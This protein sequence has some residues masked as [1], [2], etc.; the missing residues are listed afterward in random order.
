MPPSLSA[1]RPVGGPS[2]H[3]AVEA[4][5]GGPRDGSP[6][7]T[8]E[9]PGT[10]AATPPGARSSTLLGRVGSAE[11]NLLTDEASWSEELYEM[12]GR[13]PA[14]PA[15]T[16]D[17]LP[18]LVH[19]ADR[20]LLTAM[21][22]DCLVDGRPI[23]GEFRTVRPD[24]GIRT[25]HMMGEP[26]LDADGSTASMW[27]VLRD[28]GAVRRSR[29]TVGET[30]GPLEPQ[31][32]RARTGQRL[33]TEVRQTV[34]PPWRGPLRLPRQGPGSLDLAARSLPSSTGAAPG[35]TWYEAL[36]L[37][38]GDTLL[39]V[40]R[41]AGDPVGVASGLATLIGAL[42]GMALAGT[43]PGQLLGLLDQVL[44]ASLQPVLGSAVCCRYRPATR[45][46]SWAQAGHPAP[47]LYRGRTGRAL[48]APDGMPLGAAASAAYG[49]AEVTLREGD[50]LLLHTDGLVPAHRGTPADRLL[51]GLG[52]RLGGARTVQDC[53]RTVVEEF[54][55]GE[56]TDDACLL[57]AQ[58]VS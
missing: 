31:R 33:V 5:P 37:P 41:L 8:A 48:S 1:D 52:P 36:E 3:G 15:L 27:A 46:L 13:D 39:S 16:L 51:T 49:Q 50:V 7:M 6:S 53:V 4:H 18:S 12:L 24:G 47:L 40:G 11:W 42:R 32:P 54:D 57:V 10:A 14:S 20:P 19:E 35:G 55:E 44:D 22:T 38:D 30:H 25:L 45:T 2:R 43:A 26:V 9:P 29:R 21:V 58:V 28:V 34:L 56:R 17:E 23:D